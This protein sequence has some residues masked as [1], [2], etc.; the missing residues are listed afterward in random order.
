[1]S[2]QL[3]DI[4][5]SSIYLIPWITFLV[6]LGGSAHCVGMCGGLVMA[7]TRNK[8][9]M[10]TYQIGR[11]LGYILIGFIAA[12]LG[13]FIKGFFQSSTMILVTSIFMG[14]LL[15]TWGVKIILKD[16]IKLK[17]ALPDFFNTVSKFGIRRIS[18]NKVLSEST[19]SG[20][21]GFMSIFLPCGFLY[22]LVLVVAVYEN[23][24]LG[25]ISMAT[26][27][28]GTLPALVLAPKIFK[29][30]L[31]PLKSKAPL[32]SSFALISLGMITISTR[33]YQYFVFGSCH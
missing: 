7:F 2:V 18:R 1:L 23:P 20:A 32:L 6:A 16:K 27:W 24:V 33:L 26:F 19:R 12:S 4:Y 14:T 15:I 29:Y 22:G 5:T 31:G 17:L 21:L 9:T 3:D 13:S 11:L 28:I 8:K 10:T 25:M 30:V